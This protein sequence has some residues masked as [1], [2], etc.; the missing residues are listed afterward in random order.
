MTPEDRAQIEELLKDETHSYREIA[1]QTGYSDFTIRAVARKLMGNDR[2]LKSTRR[3]RDVTNGG[4]ISGW[5]LLA[6]VIGIIGAIWYF[7]K[8]G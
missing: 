6:G 3:S 2:P 1:R 5:V 7:N 4:S 8:E